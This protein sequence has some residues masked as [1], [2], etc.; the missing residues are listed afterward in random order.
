M[1]TGYDMTANFDSV[2]ISESLV[3]TLDIWKQ[4]TRKGVL[5]KSHLVGEVTRY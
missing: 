3:L 5:G 4:H 1:H 2:K